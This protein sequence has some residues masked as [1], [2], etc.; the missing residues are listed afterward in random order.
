M[1]PGVEA[2]APSQGGL[3]RRMNIR[4]EHASSLADGCAQLLGEEVEVEDI[5]NQERSDDQVRGTERERDGLAIGMHQTTTISDFSAGDVQHIRRDIDACQASG[6]LFGKADQPSARATTQ[7]HNI[8]AAQCWQQCLQIS[9]FQ[10]QQRVSLGVVGPRPTLKCFNDFSAWRSGSVR[11]G[12]A[13][14]FTSS[15]PWASA[16]R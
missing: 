16:N 6:P 9:Y 3:R 13:P 12:M 1:F 8:T 15:L 4:E 14:V 7:I 2:A 11:H 5:T 10:R